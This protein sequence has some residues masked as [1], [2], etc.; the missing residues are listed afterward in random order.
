LTGC[1]TSRANGSTVFG[2][3]AEA[4]AAITTLGSSLKESDP[5]SGVYP[6]GLAA[7]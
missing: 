6:R 4:P 5:V 2:K 1:P 7:N 3:A